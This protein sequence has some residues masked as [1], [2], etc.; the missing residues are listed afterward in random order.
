MMTFYRGARPSKEEPKRALRVPRRY[1]QCFP[2]G[3]PCLI[4][5]YFFGVK[6]WGVS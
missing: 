2:T 5:F 3:V 1:D 4:F 6:I